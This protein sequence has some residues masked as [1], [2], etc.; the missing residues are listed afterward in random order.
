MINVFYSTALRR[1]R[2]IKRAGEII[3]AAGFVAFMVSGL[4]A[5]MENL[6][7]FL[8]ADGVAVLLMITGMVVERWKR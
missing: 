1:R 2:K 7:P 5:D 6:L 4:L 3:Q 8:V